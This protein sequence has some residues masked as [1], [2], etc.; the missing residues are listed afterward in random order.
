MPTPYVKEQIKKKR[1]EED[2]CDLITG[3]PGLRLPC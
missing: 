2:C 3:V 1:N